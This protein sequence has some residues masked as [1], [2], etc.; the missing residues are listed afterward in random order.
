LPERQ[1]STDFTATPSFLYQFNDFWRIWVKDF[2]IFDIFNFELHA[3][4][5]IAHFNREAPNTHTSH[6]SR[7]LN[8][9]YEAL[10]LKACAITDVAA[11]STNTIDHIVQRLSSADSGM[12]LYNYCSPFRSSAMY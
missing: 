6:R 10:P 7:S 3:P 11:M 5:N 9:S 2:L 8:I 4:A 1:N 12:G